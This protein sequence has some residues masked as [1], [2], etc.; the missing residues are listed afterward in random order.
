MNGNSDILAFELVAIGLVDKN[1]LPQQLG[2][3]DDILRNYPDLLQDWIDYRAASLEDD[4]EETR[5]LLTPRA[6]EGVRHSR[7]WSSLVTNGLEGSW[8]RFKDGEIVH[9]QL[10]TLLY[11][12][13]LLAELEMEMTLKDS[14]SETMQ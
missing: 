1:V 3:V 7:L 5:R 10:A 12:P 6:I 4:P 13:D 14:K 2:W 11:S 9:L 8:D